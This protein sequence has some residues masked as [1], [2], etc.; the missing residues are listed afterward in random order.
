MFP[1]SDEELRTKGD[2]LAGKIGEVERLEDQKEQQVEKF[3]ESIRK[4]K[5]EIKQLA[6]A[7]RE[8]QA[9][10][11]A[12]D[13]EAPWAATLERAQ[14]VAGRVRRRRDRTGETVDDGE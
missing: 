7:I 1:L 8:R 3:N 4:A 12:T 2:E 6:K 14:A 10:R 5:A 9:E 13:T 11:E